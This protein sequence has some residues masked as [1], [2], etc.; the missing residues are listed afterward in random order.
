MLVQ[1]LL[2]QRVKGAKPGDGGSAALTE[3]RAGG[4][5]ESVTDDTK[6]RLG[7][8]AE[9]DS[10]SL[11]SP[12]SKRV[13]FRFNH[14]NDDS[15]PLLFGRSRQQVPTDPPSKDLLGA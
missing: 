3:P 2:D 8:P 5:H 15:P 1:L 11:L 7:D 10:S 4:H 13:T 9:N 14:L 12:P 6:S